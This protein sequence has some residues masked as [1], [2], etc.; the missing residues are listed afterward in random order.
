VTQPLSLITGASRGLGRA[1][2]LQ[3][4]SRG[5]HVI[6]LAR[7]QGALTELDDDIKKAGGSK[8]TLIPFDLAQDDGAF[9]RLGETLFERFGK[10][11]SLILNAAHL[12]PLSPVHHTLE[13]DWQKTFA[14]NVTANARLLRHLDPLLRAATAPEITFIACAGDSPFWGAY[15]ASK[16]ALYEMAQSYAAENRMA[17]FKVRVFDPGPIATSLRRT[18]FPGEDQATLKTAEDAAGSYF[19]AAA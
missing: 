14:V 18:A 1:L 7:T 4:A 2:A 9:A 5:A 13:K 15:A 16:R 11:D 3:Q 17:G 10:L 19:K 12:A 8:A 6:A